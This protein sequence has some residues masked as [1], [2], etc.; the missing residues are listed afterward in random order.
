M[1]EM[2][3]LPGK[4]NQSIL[5][6][7]LREYPQ[8]PWQVYTA[9]PHAVPDHKIPGASKGYATFQKLRQVGWTLISSKQAKSST[10]LAM[11]NYRHS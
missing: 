7:H 3:W 2:C 10:L 5:M 9:S 4:N 1:N 11:V 6:L 8:Q